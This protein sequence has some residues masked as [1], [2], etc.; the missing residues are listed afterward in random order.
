MDRRRRREALILLLWGLRIGCAVGALSIIV[1]A[2]VALMV[3][4]G[5]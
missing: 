4:G 3:A 5:V 2:V 1:A